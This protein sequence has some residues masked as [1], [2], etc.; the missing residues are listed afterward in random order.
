MLWGNVLSTV[1]RAQG[2]DGRVT[3]TLIENVRLVDPGAS[4]RP[5]RLLVRDGVIADAAREALPEGA[6][7][8]DGGG[9]LLTPGLIDMH[10]HGV[11]TFNYDRGPDDLLAASEVLGRYGVT[12]LAPTL[13]S[14]RTPDL[15]PRLERIAG[16]IP[17]VR[18]VS[19]AGLHLEGPFV[20]V[21]GAGCEPVDGDVG[22]VEEMIAACSGRVAVMSLSPDTRNIIPVIERLREHGVAVFMTHTRA[23]AEATLRAVDAGARHATHFYNVFYPPEP[24]EVGAWPAGA[25]EAVLA[26]PRVT[27]DIICDGV[28]VDPLLVRMALNAKG[29]GGVSLITD[30]NIGA[31]LPPQKHD[32]PWGY[33]IE[34]V[35]EGGARIDDPKHRY[36]RGLA[37]S[38]LTMDQ[39]VRN[40]L[41]W[42]FVP[43]EQ[44]WAMA[45]RNPAGVLGL[46]RK[47]SLS[48]GADADLVLWN[49]DL[50]PAR[51][52]VG[53]RC[54][55]DGG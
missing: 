6:R 12:C 43:P 10:V 22:L 9:R 8:F 36:Y 26:D 5:G 17:Q 52:F 29:W 50:T 39:G 49:E 55:Y 24:Q 34:V 46:A 33:P 4:I 21:T 41:T 25:V 48:P 15:L 13:L 20:T 32:T 1:L 3:A 23:T 37:G 47:G 45:T 53:G 40:L 42:G 2:A 28:H 35:A 18:N 30:A 54:V 19:V 51:T 27:C 31:G 16:A 11:H 14:N 38:S 7:R 44:T